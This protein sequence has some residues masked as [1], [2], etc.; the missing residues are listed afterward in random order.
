VFFSGNFDTMNADKS[1]SIKVD[2]TVVNAVAQ[3]KKR[4][5]MSI[6]IGGFFSQAALEKLERE[7]L[8]KKKTTKK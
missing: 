1:K 5:D 7:L 6:T 2:N 8:N 3:Y 4:H